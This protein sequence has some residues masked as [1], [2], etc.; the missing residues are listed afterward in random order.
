MDVAG[1]CPRYFPCAQEFGIRVVRNEAGGPYGR[2]EGAVEERARGE[3]SETVAERGRTACVPTVRVSRT[4]K[5]QFLSS[6][7]ES[8]RCTLRLLNEI[9]TLLF[10]HVSSILSNH[11]HGFWGLRKPGA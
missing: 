7:L 10:S 4:L 6:Q 3:A 11:R 9:S 2:G 8:R 5:D 1:G